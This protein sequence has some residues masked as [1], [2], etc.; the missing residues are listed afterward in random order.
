MALA[1]RSAQSDAVCW[2]IIS[3]DGKHVSFAS[4][5]ND[6][7]SAVAVAA[8]TGN[9]GFEGSVAAM[10]DAVDTAF[11][12]MPGNR[13]VALSDRR[14]GSPNLCSIPVLGHGV[15]KQLT[16]FTSGSIFACHYSPDGKLL[17]HAKIDFG[18]AKITLAG[19]SSSQISSQP[20]ATM[21]EA[22]LTGRSVSISIGRPAI[23]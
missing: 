12:W 15:E 1:R 17:G 7:I 6:A 22:H 21:D 2:P 8:E 9:L 14:S 16:H 4:I 18:L 11:C 20:T 5:R 13:S 19:A 23:W 3:L 10:T